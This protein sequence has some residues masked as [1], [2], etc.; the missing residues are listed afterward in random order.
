[1]NILR[2]VFNYIV[3]IISKLNFIKISDSLFKITFGIFFDVKKSH[4]DNNFFYHFFYYSKI[5][6]FISRYIFKFFYKKREYV[7][8]FLFSYQWGNENKKESFKQILDNFIKEEDYIGYLEIGSYAGSS[9][10]TASQIFRDQKKNYISYSI[11]LHEKIYN[12]KDIKKNNI[13]AQIEKFSSTKL[14]KN[15]FLHNVKYSKLNIQYFQT[16]VNEFFSRYLKNLKSKINIC[17]IDAGHEYYD[18][19]NDIE[20]CLNIL[21][22]CECKRGLLFGDDYS[23]GYKTVEKEYNKDY[24]YTDTIKSKITNTTFHPGVTKAVHDVIGEVKSENGIWYKYI[25]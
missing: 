23:L 8:R 15:L 19:K 11:D 16:D 20:K 24:L 2:K 18:V 14:V 12:Q 21:A 7:G 22:F 17:Y 3:Y 25:F 9:L 13:Y 1:M 6:G 4:F 10:I 5:Y